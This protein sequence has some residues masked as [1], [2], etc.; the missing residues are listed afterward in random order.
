NAAFDSLRAI[1][2]KHASDGDVIS[3]PYG[4]TWLAKEYASDALMELYRDSNE[5]W[6]KDIIR[7]LGRI[8][9]QKEMDFIIHTAKDT[10]DLFI[11]GEEESVRKE[12][13]L[14]LSNFRGDKSVDALSD[15]F[16]K[17]KENRIAAVKSL[18]GIGTRR[19]LKA[20]IEIN[21][22]VNSSQSVSL[23]NEYHAQMKKFGR[24]DSRVF[25][26]SVLR[27]NTGGLISMINQM[28]WVGDRICEELLYIVVNNR[29]KHFSA[30]EREAAICALGN[31]GLKNGSDESVIVLHHVLW[32][33]NGKEVPLHRA[34]AARA[35]GAFGSEGERLLK[36]MYLNVTN[37]N[38]RTDADEQILAG[39]K[40]GLKRLRSGT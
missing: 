9:T 2:R 34:V 30:A 17:Q 6:K 18:G 15:V 3:D 40:A 31:I 35:L 39:V 38:P 1:G 13:V 7:S 23:I 37:K 29:D 4:K 36:D 26:N 32:N 12:A 14:A 25:I 27:N 28:G 8:R 11:N 33:M 5:L 21:P 24:E 20:L 16:G 10:G 22:K 19:A